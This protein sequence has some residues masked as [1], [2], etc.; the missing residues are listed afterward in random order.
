MLYELFITHCTN[1]TSIMNPFTK[2]IYD[3][4]VIQ[5]T[6]LLQHINSTDNAIRIIVEYTRS[7]EAMLLCKALWGHV[8]FTSCCI[9]CHMEYLLVFS[10]LYICFLFVSSRGFILIMSCVYFLLLLLYYYCI[11]YVV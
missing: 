5:D 8:L 11:I 6:K 2:D 4:F 7:D 10:Y 9:L 3:M 1:G